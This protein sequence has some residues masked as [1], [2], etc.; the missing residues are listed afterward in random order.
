[1]LCSLRLDVC[2]T[3]QHYLVQFYKQ[4]L[5]IHGLWLIDFGHPGVSS[6][7]VKQID[8]EFWD[9]PTLHGYLA[10]QFVNS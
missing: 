8:F 4:Y 2:N 7:Q 6:Y 9:I 1:M 10:I 3:L 5:I